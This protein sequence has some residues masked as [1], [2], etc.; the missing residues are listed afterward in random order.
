LQPFI[1][2]ICGGLNGEWDVFGTLIEK[3]R[4]NQQQTHACLLFEG[5][6]NPKMAVNAQQAASLP[7]KLWCVSDRLS[8]SSRRFVRTTQA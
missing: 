1:A 8:S 6:Q 2:H 7:R 4:Q 3:N 5:H